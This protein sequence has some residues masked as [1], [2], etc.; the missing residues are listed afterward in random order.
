MKLRI[1]GNS[2]RLRLDQRDLNQLLIS[3]RIEEGIR[4]GEDAMRYFSYALEIDDVGGHS[5][6]IDYHSGHFVVRLSRRSA[7]AWKNSEQ[8]GFDVLQ[9]VEG[10][11]IRLLVEKDFA[12]LDRPAGEEMDD[13]FAF[14]NPQA[15]C[16]VVPDRVEN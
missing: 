9:S 14:P 11:E 1:R 16:P 8:V 15:E 4:F 12:C 10:A 3:G 2:V 6:Q 5:P 13:A 7:D